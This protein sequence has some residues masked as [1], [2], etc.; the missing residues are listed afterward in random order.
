M[1]KVISLFSGAGG[2]DLGFI[3]SGFKII[4]ANDFD[5][6]SCETYKKILEIILYMKIFLK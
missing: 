4:F 3:Q 1:K 5:K 2:L 6:D